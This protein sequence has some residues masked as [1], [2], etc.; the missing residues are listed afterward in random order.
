MIDD[1]LMRPGR[2]EVQIEIGLPKE[3]GRV[4]VHNDLST[5][6]RFHQTFFAKQKVVGAQRLA[7]SHLSISPTMDFPDFRLKSIENAPNL[8]A[9][10]QE[11]CAKKASLLALEEK[12][13]PLVKSTPHVSPFFEQQ[14]AYQ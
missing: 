3:E 6:G 7:K 8:C 13:S 1:A 14:T 4:Q 11:L 2:L 12:P 10:C 9:V 5:S